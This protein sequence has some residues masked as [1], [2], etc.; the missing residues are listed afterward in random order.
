MLDGGR[1]KGER[2]PALGDSSFIC[3]IYIYIYTNK[4][5]QILQETRISAPCDAVASMALS[6]S[7]TEKMVLTSDLTPISILPDLED[8]PLLSRPTT[9]GNPV[10]LEGSYL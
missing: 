1:G 4:Y 6:A 8:N 7:F 5:I 3:V 9:E 10:Y 2:L